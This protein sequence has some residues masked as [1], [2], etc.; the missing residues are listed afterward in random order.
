MQPDGH[1]T[2]GPIKGFPST[3]QLNMLTWQV[4][5][6]W[7]LQC[8]DKAQCN[9][10][11]T[12]LVNWCDRACNH[13]CRRVPGLHRALALAHHAISTGPPLLIPN[14]HPPTDRP[15]TSPWH[16]TRQLQRTP[17]AHDLEVTC[18][19]LLPSRCH[20]QAH[21]LPLTDDRW[22]RSQCCW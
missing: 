20:Q 2:L 11:G 4:V 7:H 16:H 14:S 13:S 3:L 6:C 8:L 9:L 15:R 21:H 10:L 17:E 5:Q 22:E 19:K 1:L 12:S 18:C